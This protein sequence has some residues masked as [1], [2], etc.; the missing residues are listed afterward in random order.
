[1]LENWG[2]H[3]YAQKEREESI[4][5]MKH[6]NKIIERILFLEGLPNLQELGKLKIGENIKEI[7]ECDLTLELEAHK[8]LK[9]IISYAEQIKDFVTRDLLQEII[10]DTEKYIDF[11]ETQRDLIEKI[12]IQNFIQSWI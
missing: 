12:G 2:I 7:I 6:A 3:K 11:L 1:M 4:E 10:N 5:E 8:L 9:E